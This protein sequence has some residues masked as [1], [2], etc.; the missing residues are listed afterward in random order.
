[1]KFAIIPALV[2]SSVIF[3][4][5]A[6]AAPRADGGH[7]RGP[8]KHAHFQ[9][10]DANNDGKITRQEA[11]TAADR[12]FDEADADKNGALTLAEM[13]A[14]HAQN[15]PSAEE[16]FAQRDANGDGKLSPQEVP[17]MAKERFAKLDG[18]QDG[19]L[20]LEEMKAKH[21][22]KA[23]RGQDRFAGADANGDGVLSR[24]EMRALK[25]AH[26]KKMDKNNDGVVTQDEVGRGRR[27]AHE[28]KQGKK[29]SQ[30]RA[31]AQDRTA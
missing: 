29:R 3:S 31:H 28:S 7:G 2:F 5:L 9:R 22:E 27:A 10:W 1:M 21:A 19:F 8:G 20:S 18:N 30:G 11:M 12:H 24:A 14:R 23:A 13:Q 16:R 6:S 26:F 25:E 4:S 15:K 17:R